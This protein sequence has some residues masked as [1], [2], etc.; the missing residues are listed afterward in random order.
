M[1]RLF[2]PTCFLVGFLFLLSNILSDCY[3]FPTLSFVFDNSP[4][5]H[6]RLSIPYL[7]LLIPFFPP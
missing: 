7:L 5:I 3:F 2:R 4:I 6:R 1:M